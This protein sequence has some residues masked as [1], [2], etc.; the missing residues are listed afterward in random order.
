MASVNAYDWAFEVESATAGSWL[1]VDRVEE[2]ELDYGANSEEVDDTVFA[3][4]GE[5]AGMVIQRGATMNLSGFYSLSSGV[6]STS[7]ARIHEKGRAKGAASLVGF[8][9]RHETEA[10][11]RVWATAYVM[12]GGIG[13][14][15]TDLT[16]F[17]VTFTK[18]GE[19]TTVTV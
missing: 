15:K 14:G 13:G 10:S 2:F 9:F 19:E 12:L 11:W 7:Q 3:N 18:S 4:N 17:E 1:T 6:R 16:S 5:Y 8:R